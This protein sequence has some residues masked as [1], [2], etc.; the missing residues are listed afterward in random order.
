MEENPTIVIVQGCF[1]TQSPYRKLSSGLSYLGYPVIHPAL[2]SCD[3]TE[4]PLFPSVDLID[5]A[6]AVRLA[7]TRLIEYGGKTVVVVMHSYG[8]LVGSEAIPKDLSHADRQTRG[9]PGGVLHLFFFSAFLLDEGE[10]VLGTWGESPNNDVKVCV[11]YTVQ[12]PRYLEARSRPQ[13]RGS[14]ICTYHGANAT[15]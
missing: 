9:L 14:E 5:D 4:D 13:S 12:V 2:P 8:G 6:L 15:N 10:S 7:L 11:D 1:Q 3:K